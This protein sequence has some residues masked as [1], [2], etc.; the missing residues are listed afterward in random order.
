MKLKEEELSVLATTFPSGVRDFLLARP[1]GGGPFEALHPMDL[2]ALDRTA[3]KLDGVGR[4]NGSLAL[5]IA[6]CRLLVPCL[7]YRGSG[8]HLVVEPWSLADLRGDSLTED[9]PTQFARELSAEQAATFRAVS[10]GAAPPAGSLAE[11][12]WETLTNLPALPDAFDDPDLGKLCRALYLHLVPAGQGLIEV[13]AAAVRRRVEELRATGFVALDIGVAPRRTQPLFRK[14]L[15]A[16]VRYASQLTG[17]VVE[18]MIGERLARA[19]RPALTAAEKQMLAVRYGACRALNDVNVGFLF[20][21]GPLLAD[22]INDYFLALSRV[23]SPQGRVQAQEHLRVVVYLLRGF[24]RRRKAARAQERRE[25]RQ[26]R[27]DAM[28]NGPRRQPEYHADAGAAPEEIA[29]A[30]EEMAD[31]EALLPQLKGRDASRLRAFIVCQGNRK[32][33]AETLGLDH[34]SYS[35]QL[36]QTV[37]PAMRRLAREQ[38]FDLSE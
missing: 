13:N 17:S 11:L 27:A 14:L 22:S 20:G 1:S 23:R 18:D 24:Q 3:A 34:Q 19:R 26:R 29:A 35:R 31:L 37:F 5:A 12:F 30:R 9:V 2:L 6:L 7:K 25:D 28:P 10:A 4:K 21:C 16:A 33:A 32:A 8:R 36:R 15:A 38:G